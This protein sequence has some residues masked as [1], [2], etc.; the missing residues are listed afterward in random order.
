LGKIADACFHGATEN[1]HLSEIGM[2]GAPRQLPGTP[3][4]GRGGRGDPQRQLVGSGDDPAARTP[5]GAGVPECRSRSGSEP[6]LAQSRRTI[7]LCRIGSRRDSTRMSSPPCRHSCSTNASPWF[8][9]SRESMS[10]LPGD[11]PSVAV[12]RSCGW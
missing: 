8:A 1:P 2:Q 5:Y 12:P 4:Q 3:V 10:T 7:H 11:P 6:T 9:R